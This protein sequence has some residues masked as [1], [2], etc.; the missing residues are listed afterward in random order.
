MTLTHF[1]IADIMRKSEEAIFSDNLTKANECV[2]Q[3]KLKKSA[4]IL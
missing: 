2:N 4:R 3:S 1:K